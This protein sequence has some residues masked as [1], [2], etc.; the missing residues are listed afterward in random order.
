MKAV[1]LE[2]LTDP[3]VIHQ[4]VAAVSGASGPATS[5]TSTSAASDGE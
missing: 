2:A 5:S 1:V 3:V 4:M